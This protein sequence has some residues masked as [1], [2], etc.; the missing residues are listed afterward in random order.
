M[1]K[2]TCISLKKH[3][4][5]GFL[6][7]QTTSSPQPR[8][9]RTKR[10]GSEAENTAQM[11]GNPQGSL[12][13]STFTSATDKKWGVKGPKIPCPL[14]SSVWTSLY[15]LL[16]ACLLTTPW[17]R[18]GP[19]LLFSILCRSVVGTDLH[20]DIGKSLN[21]FFNVFPLSIEALSMRKRK[22]HIHE[23]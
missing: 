21:R 3:H 13:G 5:L 11:T 22:C 20:C 16:R 2:K 17:A 18:R 10:R 8:V 19:P 15:F 14:H 6:N 9:L 4:R 12:T 7:V 1:A 23:V